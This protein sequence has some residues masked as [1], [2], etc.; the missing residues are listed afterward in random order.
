MAGG[1]YPV[2]HAR[3]TA[4]ALVVSGARGA[5]HVYAGDGDVGVLV[6]DH[7]DL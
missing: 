3:D 7:G 4:V 6:E 2:L 5:V 1:G